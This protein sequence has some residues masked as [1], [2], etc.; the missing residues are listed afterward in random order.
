M[1]CWLCVSLWVLIYWY[2][3]LCIYSVYKLQYKT[4]RD[5]YIQLYFL[6]LCLSVSTQEAHTSIHTYMSIDKRTLSFSLAIALISFIAYIFNHTV[7]F[8]PEQVIVIT[9]PGLRDT[10]AYQALQKHYDAEGDK[11]SI[12]KECQDANRFSKY[13]KTFKTKDG[14][15]LVCD[16]MIWKV[17]IYLPF[18]SWS[19]SYCSWRSYDCPF[20]CIFVQIIYNL[21][22]TLYQLSQ[23][24][25][26]GLFQE[27]C[28]G[29]DYEA[30]VRLG[31]TS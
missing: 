19:K 3:P 13:S 22:I 14:D 16:R 26:G 20:I 25:K 2:F 18:S 29:W 30:L 4:I 15:I 27:S 1:H 12:I 23:M 11:I 24:Y 6:F 5:L 8:C 17:L 10:P 31:Q 9:M 7:W 21:C 28:Y